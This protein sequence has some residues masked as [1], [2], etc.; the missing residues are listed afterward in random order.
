MTE[1]I[2][3]MI[4]GQPVLILK[5]GTSRSRGKEAQRAN[6]TAASV[7]A[8]TVKSSLGPKGMDK[9]LVDGLG[10]VTIT[11]DG[12]TILKEM[13]IQHPAAKMM[14]EIAKATDDEVGDGTTS[15]VVFAGKL[16]EKAQGLVDQNIHSTI[17]V[18]GFKEASEKAL[19]YLKDIAIKVSPTDDD[20]LMKV[21]ITTLS[22]KLVSGYSQ[23]LGKISV[24]AVRKVAQKSDEGYKI[25]LG[26]IKIN[27]KAGESMEESC[28]IEGIVL[29][30]EVVHSGMPKTVK[31]AN[32]ALLNTPL[33]VEKTEFTAKI[34]IESPED[35]KAFLD[36]EENMLRNMVGKVTKS[37]ANV[38]ICQKGID[39][40]AQ[41]FLAKAGVLAVRRAS[42][43]NMEAIS[44]ATGAKIVVNLEGLVDK[45]LGHAQLV[46]ER[47]MGDDKWVFIE[48]CKN[49]R[50]LTI[51]LRGGTEKVIDEAERAIHDTLCVVKDIMQRPYVV[52]GGGAPEIEVSSR[53]RKW[54]E[55][56]S[57]KEQ[58]AAIVFAEALE[59]IPIS[60]AENSGLD[61]VDILVELRSRHE[62][63]EKWAGVNAMEGRVSD[64]SKLD[65]YEPL[66]VKEQIIKAASEAAS[67]ILR[68]DDVI[69]AS[70]SAGGGMPPRP[71]GM[72]GGEGGP[73]LD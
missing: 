63:G 39:D 55:S 5:E 37:G 7:V 64:M 50:A 1:A 14:V 44:K 46:E 8:E 43:S 58:L 26:D 11:N 57:G 59:V 35:M 40:V 53:V 38:L 72:P 19:E 65:V 68:I 61:P 6:I 62:K 33:E 42:E 10:D 20:M 56:L 47:K 29:D 24:D 21:A 51:L 71:P 23:H 41:H 25:D 27:K 13:D 73:D 34:N 15:V 17:I 9:M 67:M 31:S 12:A 2:P 54:A 22:S 66:V 49:P 18:D 28:L 45:D 48:G 70:K 69:A 52:A 60:L 36:E 32:I 30:K 16:L 3:A 4:S